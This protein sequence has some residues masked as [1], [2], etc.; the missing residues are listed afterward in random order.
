M[1]PW[2]GRRS[3]FATGPTSSCRSRSYEGPT[4]RRAAAAAEAAADESRDLDGV[5]IWIT[6]DDDMVSVAGLVGPDEFIEVQ[7]PAEQLERLL[8]VL[9]MGGLELPEFPNFP[10]GDM[11]TFFEEFRDQFGDDFDHFDGF[12]DSPFVFGDGEQ[13]GFFFD[14]DGELPDFG[15][16]GHG[17]ESGE[18]PHFGPFPE[19][20]EF[21]D[22]DELFGQFQGEFQISSSSSKESNFRASS[23]SSTSTGSVTTLRL[24]ARNSTVASRSTSTVTATSSSSFRAVA[25]R[26]VSPPHHRNP[27]GK[28]HQAKPIKPALAD[29]LVFWWRG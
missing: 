14:F 20:G 24:W 19:G 13:F 8:D 17:L 6:R 22:L 3:S 28:T 2:N 18:F 9:E 23:S 7:G 21:P 27:S 10:P 4:P 25:G 1:T 5:T 26:P 12:G 16:F 29:R 15:T 11:E